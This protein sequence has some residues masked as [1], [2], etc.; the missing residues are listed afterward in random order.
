MSWN[1]EKFWNT[2]VRVYASILAIYGVFLAVFF[3][4]ITYTGNSGEQGPDYIFLTIVP[5]ALVMF[6]VGFISTRKITFSSIKLLTALTLF[7]LLSTFVEI[8]DLFI[9][10]SFESAAVSS[11]I[12]MLLSLPLA[13]ILYFI[14]VK[15]LTSASHTE[16]D[17]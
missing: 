15:L 9:G 16:K 8:F 7:L 4:Y 6:L 1:G 11:T 3:I 14:I 13:F 12:S 17:K 2:V 10:P 5:L